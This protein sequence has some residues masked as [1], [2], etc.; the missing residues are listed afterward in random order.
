[1]THVL[2]ALVLMFSLSTAHAANVVGLR[3]AA[4][5]IQDFNKSCNQNYSTNSFYDCDCAAGYLPKI[6]KD[7]QEERLAH[8]IKTM[9]SKCKAG[10]KSRHPIK[11]Q[12]K[13]LSDSCEILKDLQTTTYD[14][15]PA[16]HSSSLWMSF[17]KLNVCKSRDKIHAANLRNCPPQIGKEQ[18]AQQREIFCTCFADHM[19]DSW[20]STERTMNSGSQV[21]FSTQAMLACDKN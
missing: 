15:V 1:M 10:R 3:D 14:Q 17:V 18:S 16:P 6:V 4:S 11:N 5:Q 2:L 12:T 20:M 13:E 21:D 8:M 9:E 19:A 7:D